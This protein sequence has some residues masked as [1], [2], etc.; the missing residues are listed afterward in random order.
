MRLGLRGDNTFYGAKSFDRVSRGKTYRTPPAERGVEACP[1]HRGN[2]PEKSRDPLLGFTL[3]VGPVIACF[4]K[5]KLMPRP[6]GLGSHAPI[7]C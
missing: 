6:P 7:T 2:W 1:V 5:S 3:G 4:L